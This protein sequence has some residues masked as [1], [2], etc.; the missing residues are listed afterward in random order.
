MSK[1]KKATLTGTISK[2]TSKT[3]KVDGRETLLSKKTNRPKPW[4]KPP[5]SQR[6]TAS[7]G[8]TN[9]PKPKPSPPPKTPP[10]KS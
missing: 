10:K 9:T 3:T 8:G 2:K 1:D 4:P 7:S 5:P 6:P